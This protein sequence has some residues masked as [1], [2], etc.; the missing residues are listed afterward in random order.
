MPLP[1]IIVFWPWLGALLLVI[2]GQARLAAWVNL[3]VSAVSLVLAVA[4]LGAAPGLQGWTRIDALNQPL[5]LL[6]AV[7][8]FTTAV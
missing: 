8:G 3:G 5:V 4:L 1:W 2:P 7:I 6:S